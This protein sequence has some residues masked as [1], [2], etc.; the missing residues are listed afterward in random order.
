MRERNPLKTLVNC[1]LLSLNWISTAQTC[2]FNLPRE[3]KLS[4]RKNL[5]KRNLKLKNR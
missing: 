2:S 1:K 5:M 4:K 3:E